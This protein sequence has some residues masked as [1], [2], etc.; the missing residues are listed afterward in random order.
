MSVDIGIFLC[1]QWLELKSEPLVVLDMFSCSNTC[2]NVAYIRVRSASDAGEISRLAA[3]GVIRLMDD[4]DRAVAT[5]H[6][7]LT[8]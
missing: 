4:A 5:V 6:D 2:F 3:V 8:R 7:G 1:R